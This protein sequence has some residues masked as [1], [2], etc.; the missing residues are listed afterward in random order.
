MASV[1]PDNCRG[2]EPRRGAG[3]RNLGTRARHYT[4]R[5]P[6]TNRVRQPHAATNSHLPKSKIFPQEHP[7][8]TKRNKSS[9]CTGG[10]AWGKFSVSEGGLEGE[11]TD[12]A[13]QNLVNSGFAALPP[14]FKRGLSPSKVFLTP[15][16]AFL[17]HPQ[18]CQTGCCRDERRSR[19]AQGEHGDCPAQ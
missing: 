12:F 9:H 6:L 7:H 13:T 19:F 18:S 16:E 3:R 15:S 14:S 17:I 5:I 10:C 4:E 1:K 8:H 2:V 11:M